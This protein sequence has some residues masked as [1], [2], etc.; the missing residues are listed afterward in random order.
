MSFNIKSRFKS[1]NRTIKFIKS[2]KIVI[3]I[4]FIDLT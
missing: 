1:I 2:R 3:I 4:G